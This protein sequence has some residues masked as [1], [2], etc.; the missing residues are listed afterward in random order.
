MRT[1]QWHGPDAG[2]SVRAIENPNLHAA[3]THG[4]RGFYEFLYMLTG[5]LRHE[6][7]GRR[8]C[9]QAGQL[10]LIREG[11]SHAIRGTSC[12]CVIALFRTAWLQGLAHMWGNG[13]S[14]IVADDSAPL[15]RTIPL[16]E[17][18]SFELSLR[19]L[20]GR[21]DTDALLA[22]THFLASTL[23]R[24]F[25]PPSIQEGAAMP[26]WLEHTVT[27]LRQDMDADRSLQDIVQR[28]GRCPEHVARSFRKYLG[29]TPSQ[30]LNRRRLARAASLLTH[31]NH[32]IL[33]I[34]YEVGF[35]NPSYFHRLFREHLGMTP[36][37]YRREHTPLPLM[38]LR[39]S[40]P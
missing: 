32:S 36:R 40:N 20:I 29:T 39:H 25:L 19:G 13:L 6:V 33:D 22:F 11:E 35:E 1:F 24:Y 37:A 15:V 10:C 9:Q 38:D 31:T 23:H 7:H 21:Q 4:H 17:R 8:F 3:P 16:S 14:E 30:Y 34:C 27:W 5:T 12:T 26:D 28:C 2:F 18:Q